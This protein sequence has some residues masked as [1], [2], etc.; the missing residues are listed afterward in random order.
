MVFGSVPY[1]SKPNDAL[2]AMVFVFSVTTE[3][4]YIHEP[5]DSLAS[6]FTIET[7]TIFKY[8]EIILGPTF[9]RYEYHTPFKSYCGKLLYFIL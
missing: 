8:M 4:K 2:N 1:T 3:S 9:Y 6:S 5:I 7:H